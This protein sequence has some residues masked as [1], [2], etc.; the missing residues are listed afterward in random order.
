MNCD[1]GEATEGLENILLQMNS[2]FV[3]KLKFFFTFSFHLYVITTLTCRPDDA[4][5]QSLVTAAL[6]PL[7]F[8][9]CLVN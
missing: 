5:R 1:V 9:F 6:S 8:L 3:R 4:N 2:V 7:P